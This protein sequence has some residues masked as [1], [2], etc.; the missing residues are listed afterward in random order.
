[1]TLSLTKNTIDILKNFAQIN[2]GITVKEGNQLRTMSVAKNIMAEAEIDEHF[3]QS[4][5]IYDLNEFLAAACLFKEPVLDFGEKSVTISEKSGRNKATYFYCDETVVISPPDKKLVIPT[6][7]VTF[8]LSTEQL[9]SILKA[10]SIL[11]VPDIRV[12][13]SDGTL[14]MVACDISNPTTNS[15]SIMLDENYSGDCSFHFKAVNFKM[16]NDA[17]TVKISTKGISQFV[18]DSGDLQ[19]WIALEKAKQ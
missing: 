17:Y 9:T 1:M 10:C 19:Y 6:P 16:I 18:T 13:G 15:Y 4:F 5:S 8:Q 12:V 7:D 2:Q 14:E 11:Q 3:P